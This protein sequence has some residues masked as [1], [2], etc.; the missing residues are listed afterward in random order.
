MDSTHFTRFSGN[1][2]IKEFHRIILGFHFKFSHNNSNEKY[3]K[4][5]IFH[6]IS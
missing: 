3:P 5:G 6:F 4:Q 2:Q 1:I